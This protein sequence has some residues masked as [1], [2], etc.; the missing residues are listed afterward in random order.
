MKYNE[1]VDPRDPYKSFLLVK[2]LRTSIS[3]VH[4]IIRRI[5]HTLYTNDLSFCHYFECF[6]YV[7]YIYNAIKL[8][9]CQFVAFKWVLIDLKHIWHLWFV[10]I[11]CIYLFA[12]IIFFS[13]KD[14]FCYFLSFLHQDYL[15]KKKKHD[16]L[17]FIFVCKAP[18]AE[19]VSPLL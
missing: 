18:A 4:L 5:C 8:V 6:S 17:C 12:S 10:D 7:Y 11:F 3:L 1:R 16:F 15:K 19:F 13:I 2:D 9:L 14:M